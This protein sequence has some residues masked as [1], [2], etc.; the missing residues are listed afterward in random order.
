MIIYPKKFELEGNELKGAVQLQ[1]TEI[2]MQYQK[3]LHACYV[4]FGKTRIGVNVLNVLLPTFFNLDKVIVVCPAHL[5][6]KWEEVLQER[7]EHAGVEIE[8]SVH[9]PTAHSVVNKGVQWDCTLLI[10]DECHKILNKDSE[11]F[12]TVLQ[13]THA[14]YICLLSGSLL[15]K[16]IKF[17]KEH[18]ITTQFQVN[19]LWGYKNGLIPKYTIFNVPIKLSLK[20]KSDYVQYHNVVLRMEQELNSGNIFDPYYESKPDPESP[21]IDNAARELGLDPSEIVKMIYKWR[22][23]I[24]GRANILYKAQ[25]KVLVMKKILQYMPE[26]QAFIFCKSIEVASDLEKSVPT[27]VAIHSKKTPKQ[28]STA[29]TLFM[30]KEKPH[31]VALNMLKEGVDVPECRFAFRLAYTSVETDTEQIGGRIIRLDESNPEKEAFMFHFFAESFQAHGKN[32]GTQEITW[33]EKNLKNENN[34]ITLSSPYDAINIVRRIIAGNGAFEPLED[35][36]A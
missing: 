5:V 17:L 29:L 31:V 14:K 15:P 7:I 10:V 36:V 25:N 34:V 24:M 19:K 18:G 30:A 9:T 33:L 13:N 26:E 4:G 6:S 32:F 16:H 21:I 23:G 8:Y 28:Q 3:V 2:Q 22:A 35:E 20:E 12:S 1:A 11:Y 27:V